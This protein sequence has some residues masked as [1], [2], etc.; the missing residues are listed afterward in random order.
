MKTKKE[1]I[2]QT[3]S[4]KIAR[5]N[6]SNY[7]YQIAM[8]ENYTKDTDENVLYNIGNN[9]ERIGFASTKKQFIELVFNHVNSK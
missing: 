5:S 6:Q 4:R 8:N 7:T 9:S 1:I 2:S 3:R